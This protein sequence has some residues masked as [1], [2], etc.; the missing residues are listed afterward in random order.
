MA[1]TTY[2][3]TTLALLTIP[4][5]PEGEWFDALAETPAVATPLETLDWL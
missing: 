2:P 5:Q 1:L 4:E 3:V